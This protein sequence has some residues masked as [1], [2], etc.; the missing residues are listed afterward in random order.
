MLILDAQAALD[1]SLKVAEIMAQ[2]LGKDSKWIEQ[3]LS[4]FRKVAEKYLIKA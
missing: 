4:D 1:S 3:E 2:E